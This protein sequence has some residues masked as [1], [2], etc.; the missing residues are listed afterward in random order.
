[1]FLSTTLATI[2]GCSIGYIFK[3]IFLGWQG[4][5]HKTNSILLYLLIFNIGL[6]IGNQKQLENTLIGTITQSFIF[7]CVMSLASIF[8]T[9]LIIYLYERKFV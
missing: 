5:F 2:L 4:I 3:K 9:K 7:A 1:M 8:A 6:N